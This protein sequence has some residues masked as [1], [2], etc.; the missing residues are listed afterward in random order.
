MVLLYINDDYRECFVWKT[1][2]SQ[3]CN[4]YKYV[5]RLVGRLVV[6]IMLGSADILQ[7][8]DGHTKCLTYIHVHVCMYMCVNLQ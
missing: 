1:L 7:S 6:C 5:G 2:R 8:D 3:Q 4:I